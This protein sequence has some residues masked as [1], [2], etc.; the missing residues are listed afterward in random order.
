[1]KVGFEP[2]GSITQLAQTI[3]YEQ[4]LSIVQTCFLQ[5]KPLLEEII[6]DIEHAIHATFPF[7]RQL[8]LSI[9]KKNPPLGAKVDSSEVSLVREYKQS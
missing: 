3:N 4:L 9:Q 1:V 5:P 2:S 8:N 6:L 7:I